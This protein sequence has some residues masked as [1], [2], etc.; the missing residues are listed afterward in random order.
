M[1]TLQRVLSAFVILSAIPIGMLLAYLT[2]D[3]KD[4]YKKYFPAFLWV[5]AILA[6]IFYT[7][8]VLTALVLTFVF[9]LVFTWLFSEKLK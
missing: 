9:I 3:E 8:N 4:I 7:M 2:K 1:Q 5:L 6:A